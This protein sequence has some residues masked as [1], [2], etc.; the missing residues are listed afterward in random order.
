M[1]LVNA[2]MEHDLE[3][4]KELL[5]AGSD[6]NAE[7]DESRLRPM[8]FAAQENQIEIGELLIKA[9]A[10]IYARTYPDEETPLEIATLHNNKE[11][12]EMLLKHMRKAGRGSGDSGY[13]N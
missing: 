4:V 7:I 8:H 11:F 6:P 1:K 9:G 3:R 2:I 12:V 13:I 5:D 10:D